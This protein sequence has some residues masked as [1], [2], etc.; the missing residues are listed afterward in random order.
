MV[1]D[2]WRKNGF[3]Q[4]ASDL[5][6]V[7]RKLPDFRDPWCK[8]PGRLLEDLPMTSIIICF[9]N[10]AWSTLL[11]T[12]HSVLDRS[13][14]H[15]VT[16]VILFDDFSDLPHTKQQLDDY[17]ASY[18][19]VKVVRAS[20]RLGLI[21]ARLTATRHA[22]APILTYLDSHCECTEGWLEPLLDRIARNSTTVVCPSI[23]FINGSTLWYDRSSSE[24]IGGF[25]WGLNFV[26]I[27]VSKREKR[28][29]NHTAEPLWS[30]TMAGGLFSIDR[31]FFEQIGT[32]DTG[33]DIW[34]GENLELSFKIWMCGGTLEVVPCSRVGH[35]FRGR[36]NGFNQYASD[37]VSVHRKLPDFRDPWCKQPGRLLEDLPM[38]SIIICFYNEAWSTLLRT[39]HSVLDRSPLHLVT[40]VILFDDFSDLP[41]T[42]QQLDDYM[43]SY[44]KVKV[45]RASKRL[46]L[47]RARL[48]ATRHATAPILTYLD[49]HCECTEGWLEPLLDRIA[50]NSTT[51]VCPS[52]DFI[53]GSTLWYDR[54]SSEYIGGFTWGLNFVF[55][56][57]SKREKRR[58]NHTAE[59]LWSPTMA[60]GLF[61]IDRAFFEQIGTY[62]TGFDIWGG[63]N[64]ELSFKIW[65]CGGTLEVVPCSRVGHIF[66]GSRPYRFGED[67]LRRNLQWLADVWLDE[68]SQIYY[69]YTARKKINYGDVSSRKELRKKLGYKYFKWYI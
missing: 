14:L 8:Q 69:E 46:G 61:S 4:Y 63:E 47:I 34:G 58:H 28:R 41:H 68:Y 15:L 11:R 18:T 32:Y 49:S 45:V 36:K 25:T 9:Y 57:V 31:A 65:M 33:F 26:F 12:V 13:P 21:R 37:L 5:V 43:A 42:K 17:M 54:S 10:E 48:T 22:T 44:T 7:H 20:K 67:V 60:G 52:I 19:K 6:S 59:P 53:N 3:N 38:T 55:I 1:D 39:V 2:G 29:H 56:P 27:P 35:I 51:V 23:D 30:P 62:D 66:R 16:E 24:Y 40:E 64:L 50:R